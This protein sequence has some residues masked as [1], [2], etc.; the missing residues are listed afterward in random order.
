MRLRGVLA[1]LLSAGWLAAL[2]VAG[3]SSDGA[4]IAD[5]S[6]AGDD[7]SDD[8]AKA[9]GSPGLPDGATTREGGCTAVRGPCDLVV[10]DCPNDDKERAQECVVARAASGELTTQCVP[11]QPSQLLPIG[12]GCCPGNDNPC[13]PGLSC[14]GDPCVEGGPTT[15]RCTPACCEGDHGACGQSD[16]EGIGGQCD[17]TLFVESSEVHRVCSYRERCKPFGVEP[18]KPGQVCLV[19]DKVGT[20]GCIG[21]NGVANRQPCEFGNDCADGLICVG[22][23]GA[24]F[25]R[26]TCLTPNSNPPFDASAA[27]GEPGRGGCPAGEACRGPGFQNLP[28]WLQLCELPDGG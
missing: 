23:A 16:P 2:A 5:A 7:A 28:D 3:C 12:R 25:C 26:M 4:D 1:V 27:T 6:G 8:G 9:D 17:L 14:V 18:C 15:A 10:Q 11:V 19:E 20:A 21:S 24:R 13:L 22:S